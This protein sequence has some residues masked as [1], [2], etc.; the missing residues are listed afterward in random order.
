Y[1]AADGGSIFVLKD[2]GDDSSIDEISVVAPAVQGIYDLSGRKLSA[3]V[4]GINII[5]GKKVLVK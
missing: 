4:R 5:N 1:A 3:P 2:K